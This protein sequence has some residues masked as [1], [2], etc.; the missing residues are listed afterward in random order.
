MRAMWW[1]RKKNGLTR[2]ES[3]EFFTPVESSS[4]SVG[5][6]L[7]SY[8]PL[9]A[10]VGGSSESTLASPKMIET[11]SMTHVRRLP[12]EFELWSVSVPLDLV[13]G[14]HIP[15]HTHTPTHPHTYT[16]THPHTRTTSGA[17]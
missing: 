14:T 9:Q 5:D 11:K 1:R 7:E 2:A 8:P 6:T 17:R 3:L 10:A 4:S 16:P 12:E 15:T 13:A